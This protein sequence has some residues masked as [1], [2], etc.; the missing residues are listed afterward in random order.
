MGKWQ[1]CYAVF[2]EIVK[3]SFS[4]IGRDKMANVR[5]IIKKAKKGMLH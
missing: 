5:E 2:L 4:S 3:E 1:P